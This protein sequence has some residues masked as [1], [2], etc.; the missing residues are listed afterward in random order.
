MLKTLQQK[1]KPWELSAETTQGAIQKLTPE[2]QE[3]L[4]MCHQNP[5]TG[6][7]LDWKTNEPQN[8]PRNI[9]DF[10]LFITK[11]FSFLYAENLGIQNMPKLYH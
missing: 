9:Y 5:R 7:I 4:R 3:D 10:Y 6:H 2:Q 8:M 11:M 1:Y